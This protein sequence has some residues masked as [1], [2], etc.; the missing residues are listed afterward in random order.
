MARSRGVRAA[1][2]EALRALLRELRLQAKLTQV[3]LSKKLGKPQSYISKA[4]TGERRL[5]LIEVRAICLACGT[6]LRDFAARLEKQLT[7][8]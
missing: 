8:C 6:T 2:R 3:A 7:A 5:D 1:E 4:E